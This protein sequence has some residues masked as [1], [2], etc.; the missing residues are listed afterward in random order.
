MI[1]L[2]LEIVEAGELLDA[3]GR[4]RVRGWARRPILRYDRSRVRAPWWRV[5]EW[6][7]YCVLCSK[8][9]FALTCADLGYLGLVSAV[10]LDFEGRRFHQENRTVFLPRGRM[11]LPKSSEEE[12]L[13]YEDGRVSLSF[14]KRGAERNVLVDWPGFMRGSGLNVDVRL[15]EDPGADSMVIVVP[16]RSPGQFYYNRKVNCMPADGGVVVCGEEKRFSGRDCF[17]VLDWGRGVWPYSCEWYWGSLSTRL[18]DERI[19]GF[20][21]GYG[22]GDTSAATEN[23]VFVDGRGHK[24]DQVTFHFDQKD[25]LNP[26]R[27]TS[28]DGRFEMTMEPILDRRSKMNLLVL[29]SV[30]HQVFGRFTGRAVLDDGSEVKIR[31]AVGFAEYV[32]NRW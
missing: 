3:D 25:Y 26:W 20:N 28:N 4:L 19:F 5:K 1:V 16:F 15:Y 14:L 7:Y 11:G 29:K 24:L 13:V 10:W 18:E 22:F 32:V 27:F 21:I 30:Q 23:I 17:G 9:G 31:K 8:Y 12:D 6:D 2:Q